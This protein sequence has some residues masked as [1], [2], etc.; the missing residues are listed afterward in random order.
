LLAQCVNLLSAYVVPLFPDSAYSPTLKMAAGF[1]ETTNIC[2]A[3]HHIP[4]DSILQMF[5]TSLP[6]SL[7]GL[8]HSPMQWGWRA[9]SPGV[10]RPELEIDNPSP[11]DAEIK[12]VWN[13]TSGHPYPIVLW[14]LGTGAASHTISTG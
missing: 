13:C 8:F 4:Q 3:T 14:C 7:S 5:F 2:Q 11:S 6:R 9:V 10:T 12:N 1:F